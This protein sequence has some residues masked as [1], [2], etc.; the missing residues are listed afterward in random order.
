MAT[1]EPIRSKKH[2]KTLTKHYLKNGEFRNY[3]LIVLG[4]Y[5]ALRISDLLSLKWTD[6]Y[7]EERN[8]FMNHITLVEQKTGKTKTFAI[9]PKVIPALRK[10]MEE[11]HGEYIF[12]N[13]RKNEKPISR[14]QA[15]RIIHEAAELLNIPGNIAC[16]SLRKTWGY[17]AWSSGRVSPVLIMEIY[18]HSS[19][20]VTRRYL[21]VM[22]DDIDKAYLLMND[23]LPDED[24]P[25][26]RKSGKKAL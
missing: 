8:V 7:D 21:G 12:S 16:H 19:Y 6:V 26:G 17:H 14:V 11:R 22:Q 15:W 1:V 18:N 3:A 9:P 20:K 2:L 25:N 4:V 24:L 10:C 13:N 5:T 23:L